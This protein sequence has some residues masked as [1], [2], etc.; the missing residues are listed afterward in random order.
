MWQAPTSKETENRDEAEFVVYRAKR[1]KYTI[2]YK[3]FLP[4]GQGLQRNLSSLTK[5]SRSH[6]ALERPGQG[7]LL[8]SAAAALSAALHATPIPSRDSGCAAA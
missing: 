4:Q 8:L 5:P 1:A 7:Q 6:P 3:G 2:T